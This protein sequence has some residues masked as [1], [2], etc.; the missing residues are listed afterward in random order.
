MHNRRERE[1]ARRYKAG[2]S[3]IPDL[4][5]PEFTRFVSMKRLDLQHLD[6]SALSLSP[7]L[8]ILAESKWLVNT[9]FMLFL[10]FAALHSLVLSLPTMVYILAWAA[11]EGRQ[12]PP[13][14][15]ELFYYF[16]FFIFCFYLA[17]YEAQYECKKGGD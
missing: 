7:P 11:A 2:L 13:H 4:F 10:F 1:S 16:L 5:N 6:K 15:P 8:S 9:I 3:L 12:E 14:P 17:Q